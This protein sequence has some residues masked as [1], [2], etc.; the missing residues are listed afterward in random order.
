MNNGSLASVLEY[1]RET[2]Q[3]PSTDSLSDVELLELFLHQSQQD[4][5][6]QLLLRHGPMVMGICR[7][8]LSC[9]HE[10][11]DAFQATFLILAR[12][13]T[14]IRQREQL[15]S[16]LYGVATRTAQKLRRDSAR[17][18]S[19]TQEHSEPW[20]EENCPVEQLAQR[21]ARGV[22]DEEIQRLPKRYRAPVIL[23]YLQGQT[24][25]EAAEKIG[26]PPGTVSGQLAR[27]RD[28]L[29]ARLTRRGLT[30]SASLISGLLIPR[31][32]EAQMPLPLV[33]QTIRACCQAVQGHP[34][35]ADLVSQS[36]SRLVEGVIQTMQ[37]TTL[38]T[39]LVLMLTLSLLGV[40]PT[41]PGTVATAQPPGSPPTSPTPA[42]ASTPKAEQ[43]Q[44]R[45][46]ELKKLA[47]DITK[48][49]H[50]VQTEALKDL[51]K[52]IEQLKRTTSS[53]AQAQAIRDF[54]NAFRRLKGTFA[55]P[56]GGG[57]IDA[58][59][60]PAGGAGDF[61]GGAAPRRGGHNP[62][63]PAPRNNFDPYA[64]PPRRSVPGGGGGGAR[65][66]SPLAPGISEKMGDGYDLFGE[67]GG[68]NAGPGVRR[69]GEVL[70]VSASLNMVLISLGSTDGIRPGQ[71]LRIT[72]KNAQPK[73]LGWVTVVHV[74]QKECLAELSQQNQQIQTG[75][76][77]E[78]E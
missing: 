9:S 55:P 70:K 78:R 37:M 61:L 42:K 31:P 53:P 34:L 77:A 44:K 63:A 57:G 12:Q 30:L 19:V 10:A 27:A 65:G 17:W 68:D 73:S 66:S 33:E 64:A 75:D 23:C 43:L 22:I 15:A 59:G 49:R 35:C 74:K 52:A 36:V 28:L 16:W 2:V 13:G 6:E 58:F 21:E 50:D 46:A 76:R 62:M 11:E 39:T 54:E 38:K 72:R 3:S 25:S 8:I 20:T 60:D 40:G 5:F 47:E 24:Y 67:G 48:L 29:R 51:Q 32:S 26:C 18:Q 1:L 7:R 41:S 56:G 45:I 71:K 4:A 14:S 69:T